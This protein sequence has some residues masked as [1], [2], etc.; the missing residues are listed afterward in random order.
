M[1]VWGGGGG[2]GGNGKWGKWGGGE[3][4]VC[5]VASVRHFAASTYRQSGDTTAQLQSLKRAPLE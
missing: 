3:G 5:I 1:C 4:Y 2:G